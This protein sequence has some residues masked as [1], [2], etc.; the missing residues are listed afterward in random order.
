MA[1]KFVPLEDAA[2]QLGI[3]KERL[4][5]LREAG[6]VR[7]YRDGASW[8]FRG[9]DL[10]A[11]AKELAAPKDPS[12]S[13]LALEALEDPSDPSDSIL[14]SDA[15]VGGPPNRPP[16]TV[17]GEKKGKSASESDLELTLEEEAPRGGRGDS[18][19]A[20]A[21]SDVLASSSGSHV[22]GPSETPPVPSGKFEDLDEIEIDLETESSKIQ[23]DFDLPKAPT[24]RAAEEESDLRIVE[25]GVHE[26]RKSGPKG[27]GEES[28][29]RLAEDEEDDLV[30][31]ESG[32]SDV[33]L[34][35]GDSGINLISPSDSGLALD[36]LDLDLG[37][38]GISSLDVAESAEKIEIEE[39]PVAKSRP[40][41]KD[42]DFLLTPLGEPGEEDSSSQVIELDSAAELQESAAI[43]TE[44]TEETAVLEPVE[45]EDQVVLAERR[46][47]APAAVIPAEAVH[48]TGANVA[49][50]SVCVVILAVCGLMMLDLL[51]NIW[52]WDQP[53]SVNA[54]LMESL[55][56]FS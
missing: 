17:I 48:F 20:A 23:S 43:L 7:A 37:G 38:S 40:A 21:T 50:L 3:S 55:N 11:L 1:Q 2:D 18:R 22:L 34:S 52:S 33:T 53:H 9:E 28:G 44:R 5:E 56:F 45:D 12:V 19:S 25:S 47:L 10:T 49:F 27:G 6:K 39:E 30:L 8:K 29:I 36:E 35:A 46:G 54:W 51:R 24:K 32:G 41:R 14:V 31:S 16:S 15:E 4:N 13:D 26:R 42:D